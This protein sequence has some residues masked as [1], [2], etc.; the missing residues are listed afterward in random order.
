MIASPRKP[1]DGTEQRRVER[2]FSDIRLDFF[3]ARSFR[4]LKN[5]KPQLDGWLAMATNVRGAT[6]RSLRKPW[7]R[8]SQTYKGF[9][10]HR[11]M[12]S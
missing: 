7:Q 5:L 3:L 11:L 8:K 9:Q 10:P 4:N 12:V 1:A 2:P 6:Q